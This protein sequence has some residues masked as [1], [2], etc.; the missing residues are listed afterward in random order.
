MDLLSICTINFSMNISLS[1]AAK[2]IM[3]FDIKEIKNVGR[4]KSR[5]GC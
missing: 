3:S 5:E 4:G 2:N 1:Y